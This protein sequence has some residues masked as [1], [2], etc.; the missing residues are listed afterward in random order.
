MDAMLAINPKAEDV[1][2]DRPLILAFS[3]YP[4][5]SSKARPSL[6]ASSGLNDGYPHLPVLV[7]GRKALW[8]MDTGANISAISDA[9]AEVLGLSVHPVETKIQD[10]GGS[11]FSIKITEVDDLLIGNC[12]LQHVSFFVLPHTQPP[13]DGIPTDQQALLGIQVLR[14]LRTVRITKREQVE[15]GVKPHKSGTWTP[16]AFD[17][18]IPVLQLTFEGK[19]LNFT[20]DSGAQHTT[21]NSSFASTFPRTVELGEKK[22][23]KLTGLG[24]STMQEAIEIPRLSFTLANHDVQLSPATILLQK[25]TG[26]SAWAAGNLGFDLLRQTE[27]F[28][29]DFRDMRLNNR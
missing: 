23:H 12:H 26:T 25:T 2:G 21:L 4:D 10:I 14:A 1:L 3:Q 19:P 27:P 5:Q 17:Q 16:L 29:I 9:E 13:F 11:S 28:T 24:G 6:L 18:A 7:N 15:V 8:S 22:Q 20:L